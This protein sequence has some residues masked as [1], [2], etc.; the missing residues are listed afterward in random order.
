MGTQKHSSIP[1]E[2][3][4][5]AAALRQ[6]HDYIGALS[7]IE[8]HIASFDGVYRVQGRLQGFYAAKEGGLLD[9]A[10]ALALQISEEDPNIPSV[11]AFLLGDA[12]CAA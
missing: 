10:H 6:T 5:Q 3:I 9:K 4:I 7:L 2:L 12:S 1:K 8:A 11:E